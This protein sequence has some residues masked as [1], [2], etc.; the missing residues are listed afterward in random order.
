MDLTN[1]EKGLSKD[2]IEIITG[3]NA[4]SLLKIN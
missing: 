4:C 3:S 2:Q 1:V